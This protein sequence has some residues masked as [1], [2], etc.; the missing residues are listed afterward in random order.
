MLFM[1]IITWDPKGDMETGKRYLEWKPR[2]L[3]SLLLNL[4][5]CDDRLYT[6]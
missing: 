5:K 2:S 1:E 6:I 3:C 4:G